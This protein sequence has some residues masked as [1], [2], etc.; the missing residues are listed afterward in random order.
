MWHF[1]LQYMSY[2]S[3][4]RLSY[5]TKLIYIA[6]KKTFLSLVI[7]RTCDSKKRIPLSADYP[8]L[9]PALENAPDNNAAQYCIGPRNNKWRPEKLN[10]TIAKEIEYQIHNYARYELMT[11]NFKTVRI[12]KFN[13]EY[14]HK[15][16]NVFKNVF[17]LTGKTW[18]SS[19]FSSKN[20]TQKDFARP[21]KC[22]ESVI[23]PLPVA[24][25]AFA[26]AS[27]L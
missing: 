16:L 9:C 17:T 1:I 25:L 2:K 13:N 24:F 22:H 11:S 10:K 6:N 15:I 21:K 23:L 18:Q 27:V 14:C 19:T 7:F 5:N 26:W 8:E 12:E 3:F 4:S 20:H